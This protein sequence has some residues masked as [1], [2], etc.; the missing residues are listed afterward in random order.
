MRLQ[1]IGKNIE[2]PDF[3]DI[4]EQFFTK[5]NYRSSRHPTKNGYYVVGRPLST[6]DKRPNVAVI[7]EGEPNE[8]SIEVLPVDPESVSPG[9]RIGAFLI[10]TIA[11]LE[12]RKEAEKQDQFIAF[13]K[14]FWDFVR[15]SIA[16]HS[17]T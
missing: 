14:L 7:V 3:C 1:A 12:I 17:K 2:L 15:K 5:Q 4:V 10:G 6:K 8:F 13:E 11:G 9:T 16:E